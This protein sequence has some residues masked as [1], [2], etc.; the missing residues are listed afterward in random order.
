MLR[1]ELRGCGT[2]SGLVVAVGQAGQPQREPLG[3]RWFG[4]PARHPGQR[5]RIA[6][7]DGALKFA[8]LVAELAEV[9]ILRERA[10]LEAIESW[11]RSRDDPGCRFP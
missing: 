11:R 1:E 2:I 6:G 4:V 3:V 5:G 7:A 8:G 10:N 9:R